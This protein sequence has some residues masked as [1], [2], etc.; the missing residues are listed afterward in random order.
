MIVECE[1]IVLRQTKALK[2]RRV[3]TLFTD[4]YGKISAGTSVSEKGKGR[5]AL[6]VR[7]FTLGR[8]ALRR[9][10]AYVNIVS[11]EAVKSYYSVGGD[12]EKYV[13]VS[14]ALEFA[15]RMLP[16]DAPA[17]ELWAETSRFMEMM[18]V[19]SRAHRTL[20]A[21]WLVK[22]LS[23]AGVLPG[24][25]NFG[26]DKL[27]SSLGFDKLEALAWLMANPMERVAT[28]ALD[29]DVANALIGALLR[30]AERH[31]DIGN[32]KSEALLTV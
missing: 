7:P 22:A 4:R 8:Y 15:G 13:N 23:F 17:P 32:L 24:A 2:G 29:D 20:T 6:A 18:S 11:A 27:F 19:R 28:L 10:R 3:I 1:G 16:E 25:E 26:Q 5:S 14:L 12:Y 21:V 9:D 30:F 31:L